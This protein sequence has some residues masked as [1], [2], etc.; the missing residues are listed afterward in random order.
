MSDKKS[1][2][3]GRVHF[4]VQGRRPQSP[5]EAEAVFRHCLQ[6]LTAETIEI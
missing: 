5:P 6:I 2:F 3:G 4:Q 1:I